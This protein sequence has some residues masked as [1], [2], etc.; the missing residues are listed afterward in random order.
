MVDYDE[1]GYDDFFVSRGRIHLRK[2]F[3][4]LNKVTNEQCEL[5][6]YVNETSQVVVRSLG[7]NKTSLVNINQLDNIVDEN[8]THI[9][10]DISLIGD[11]AWETA[12]HRFEVIKPLIG[13]E[14]YGNHRTQMLKRSQES[15]VP[16]NTLYRWL[17]N[18][19][20]MGSIAGLV[21]RK[22]GWVEGNTRLQPEQETIIER[23][24]NSFYLTKQR[25]TL[26]QTYREVQRLCRLQEI[27]A[28]S[29]KAIFL[30]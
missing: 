7:D 9:N 22:R 3:V 13:S 5:I 15:N 24:I 11:E 25:A 30:K 28:P 14:V 18:Y 26:E 29:K 21:D 23:A 19:R 10:V 4:Y 1:N 16:I 2:G 8:N 6:E 27:E 12:Q 20:S 17:R